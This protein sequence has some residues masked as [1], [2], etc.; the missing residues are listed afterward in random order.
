MIFNTV[1]SV[2]S[3]IHSILVDGAQLEVFEHGLPLSVQQTYQL[4]A[5]EN[6][7]T[8]GIEAYLVYSHLHR[9]GYIVKRFGDVK[10]A[11]A[12]PKKTPVD[13]KHKV[14]TEHEIM[15]RKCRGWWPA[16]DRVTY[17]AY[18]T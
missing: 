5:R 17:F 3:L 14:T 6:S 4:L 9:L 11:D 8:Y 18:V 12:P 16:T 1:Q 2:L 15:N 10:A 7:N 13:R